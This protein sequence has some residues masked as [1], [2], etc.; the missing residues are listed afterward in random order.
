MID[1]ILFMIIGAKLEILNGWYLFLTIL[2]GFC[3]ATFWM[4]ILVNGSKGGN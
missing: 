1:M 3:S 2:K 4:L